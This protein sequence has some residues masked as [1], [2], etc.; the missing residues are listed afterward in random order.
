MR[1]WVK[2]FLK[3]Y[4][5]GKSHPK[6]V[7][8]YALKFFELSHGILHDFGENEIEYLKMGAY[9]HDIGYFISSKDHQKHSYDLIMNEKFEDFNSSQKQIIANIARYH[10]G[11]LPK[12]SHKNFASLEPRQKELVLKLGAMVKMADGFDGCEFSKECE[13]FCDF[14]EKNRILTFK[15][16]SEKIFEPQSLKSVLRKRDLFEEG[17]DVQVLF[18]FSRGC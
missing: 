9:L 6:R 2:D 16:V 18:V 13:L 10:R 8:N 11:G 1:E 7:K 17:F 12:E 5:C 4:E 15:I 14:D 3:K